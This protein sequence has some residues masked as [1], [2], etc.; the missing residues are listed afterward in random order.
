MFTDA[1]YK[2]PKKINVIRQ[3]RPENPFNSVIHTKSE[4]LAIIR[5]TNNED[6]FKRVRVQRGKIK[7]S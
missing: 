4:A 3:L 5:G 1:D 6:Q 7:G 2:S